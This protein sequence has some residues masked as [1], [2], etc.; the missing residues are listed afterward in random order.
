MVVELSVWRPKIP[1]SLSAMARAR[2]P[3]PSLLLS[4]PLEAQLPAAEP[5][6]AQADLDL[7][8]QI[9]RDAQD[10]LLYVCPAGCQSEPMK[11]GK[12]KTTVPFLATA[13]P[14]ALLY[15]GTSDATML[16]K[17]GQLRRYSSLHPGPHPDHDVIT[18]HRHGHAFGGLP[19]LFWI[20]LG[21][22]ITLF[23]LFFCK[24]IYNELWKDNVVN[25]ENWRLPRY[26]ADLRAPEAVKMRAAIKAQLLS[27]RRT[28]HDTESFP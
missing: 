21:L 25:E 2:P 18:L 14:T 23:H 3:R 22:L 10:V 24:I 17:Y 16:M 7:P 12:S 26:A 15:F 28:L 20:S 6:H 11:V 4:Q 8:L 9:E 1:L 27:K 19:W 13:P 5:D